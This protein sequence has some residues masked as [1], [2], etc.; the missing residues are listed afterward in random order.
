MRTPDVALVCG[1]RGFRQHTAGLAPVADYV[2]FLEFSGK[3]FKAP[4]SR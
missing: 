1:N 4:P 3:C 2:T